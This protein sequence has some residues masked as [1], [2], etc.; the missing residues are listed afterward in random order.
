MKLS[1]ESITFDSGFAQSVTAKSLGRPACSVRST[2]GK[3]R[4]VRMTLPSR[5][6]V[7]G[8]SAGAGDRSTTKTEPKGPRSTGTRTRPASHS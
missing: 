6:R 3:G 4:A 5:A 2:F 1:V 8:F 7:V